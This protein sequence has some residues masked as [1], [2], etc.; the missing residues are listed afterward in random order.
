MGLERLAHPGR[1]G[2][3]PAQPDRALTSPAL[4]ILQVG[5]PP[6]DIRAEFGDLPH[7]FR[8]ALGLAP[9]ALRVVRVFDGEPLP[10]PDA[11]CVAII[12]GSWAMV[13]E[14]LPWSEAT[15]QWIREAMA[16]DMPLFGVC[17]GHQLMAH[18]LGGRVDY[19]PAGRE[20]G[21]ETVHLL[22]AAEDDPL[23]GQWP[24]RFVAHLTHEQTVLELPPGAV[25]LARSDHDPHQVVRY[26]RNA[27]STQFHPEFTP[28]LLAACI[29][30]RADTLRREQ[31]DP[32]GLL[33]GLRE[34]PEAT[35]LLRSF[36]DDALRLG[37][38]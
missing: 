30:R 31:R 7:W 23:L 1:L 11:S 3:F 27:L 29:R 15:A 33:D 5:T 32:Q 4:L 8:T 37:A 10:A 24:A 6:E 22:P 12:T 9:E 19:H 17:Y 14:R 13:S 21:C 2:P 16:I 20:L 34:T 38:G 28:E 25:V 26:G 18:A 36:V 35:R